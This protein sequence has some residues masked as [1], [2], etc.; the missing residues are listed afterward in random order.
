MSWKG[1]LVGFLLGLLLGRGRPPL[2]VVGLVLG[3]LF[4][5]GIATDAGSGSNA[6]ARKVVAK[7]VVDKGVHNAQ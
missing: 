4:D 6:N 7:L 1:K 3:Q 2:I 5:M